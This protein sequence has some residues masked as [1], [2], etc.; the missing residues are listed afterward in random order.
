MFHD[1]TRG[2][3][4]EGALRFARRTGHGR[5]CRKID[6]PKR[7]CRRWVQADLAVC[8]PLIEAPA[9]KAFIFDFKN[10]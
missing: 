4:L 10:L 5:Q 6:L 8:R 1:S 9:L 3:D 7:S 2:S